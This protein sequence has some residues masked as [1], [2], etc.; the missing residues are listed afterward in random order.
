MSKGKLVVISGA[1]GVGK[2]TV[3]DI[4]MKDRE[5][6]SFFVAI[7]SITWSARERTEVMILVN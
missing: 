7:G 1:S 2:G 5:D 4:M 6:L 3:L